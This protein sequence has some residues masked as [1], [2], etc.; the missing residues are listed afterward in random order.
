MI[1]ASWLKVQYGVSNRWLSEHLQ[2]GNIYGISKLVSAETQ[3]GNRR[4]G[5]WRKLGMPKTKA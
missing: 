3:R 2:M 1:L 4:K 5:L